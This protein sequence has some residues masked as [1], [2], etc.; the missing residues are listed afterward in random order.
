MP[1]KRRYERVAFFSSV[2]L[3]VLPYGPTV[4]GSSF[5]ISIGGVGL[6]AN[7][8]LDRGQ[9]VRVRFRL[10]KGPNGWTEEGVDGRVAYSHANEDSNRIGIEFLAT[11][12]E[13]TQPVLAHR[14]DAL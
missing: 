4:P 3:T 10:H 7:V 12:H 11:V 8:F 1:E 2:Q 13:S 6:I 9:S 14:L 5:D